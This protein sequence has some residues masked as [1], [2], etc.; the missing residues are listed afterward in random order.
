MGSVPP[1]GNPGSAPEKHGFNK[2]LGILN[3][4]ARFHSVLTCKFS[5]SEEVTY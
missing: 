3:Q 1:T 5:Y 2:E 4:A